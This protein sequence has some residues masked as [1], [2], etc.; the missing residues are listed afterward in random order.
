MAVPAIQ[1]NTHKKQLSEILPHFTK[2]DQALALTRIR[3]LALQPPRHEKVKSRHRVCDGTNY[4]NGGELQYSK[5]K[6]SF[7][8]SLNTLFF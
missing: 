8:C 1:E 7:Q 5:K 4:H 3:S 6:L 2:N